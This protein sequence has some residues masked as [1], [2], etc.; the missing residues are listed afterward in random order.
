MVQSDQLS[1]RSYC[2]LWFLESGEYGRDGVYERHEFESPERKL[3]RLCQ[4]YL[5]CQ[6]TT[7]ARRITKLVFVA[8][9]AC[10][11]NLC[12]Y[13][14]QLTVQCIE[15]MNIRACVETQISFPFI[16]ELFASSL[17]MIHKARIPRRQE[18]IRIRRLFPKVSIQKTPIPNSPPFFR[19]EALNHHAP[20]RKQRP[21]IVPKSFKQSLRHKSS[22]GLGL[23]GVASITSSTLS[24]HRCGFFSFLNL[25]S[26]LMT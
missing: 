19:F 11:G 14:V 16:L 24:L 8:M 17:G 6:A 18:N 2:S 4:L 7:R 20:S 22:F 5:H 10:C 26:T 23:L 21:S 13:S 15:K 12:L 9:F 3:A 1:D 25:S